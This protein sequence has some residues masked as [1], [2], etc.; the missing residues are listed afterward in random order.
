MNFARQVE[1]RLHRKSHPPFHPHTEAPSRGQGCP[2]AAVRQDALWLHYFRR[3]SVTTNSVAQNNRYFISHSSR[4]QVHNRAVHRA[5][6]PLKVVGKNFS[7]LWWI[8][9]SLAPCGLSICHLHTCLPPYMNFSLC[10]SLPLC[11]LYEDTP[12]ILPLEPPSPSMASS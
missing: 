2:T 5:V 7:Q 10:T 1:E 6:L 9:Q 3:T 8:Q 4:G 11:P 12:L